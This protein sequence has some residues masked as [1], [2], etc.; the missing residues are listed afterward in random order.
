VLLVLFT[1]LAFKTRRLHRMQTK[2]FD[3]ELRRIR[4]MPPHDDQ[5]R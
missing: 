3:R 1:A 5:S 4:E 2:A